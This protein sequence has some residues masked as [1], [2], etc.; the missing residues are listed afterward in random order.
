MLLR[1]LIRVWH[2][3]QEPWFGVELGGSGMALAGGWMFGCQICRVN[4][5]I[6][7]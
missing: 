1:C 2:T 6:V 7:I 4:R 5:Q 3:H